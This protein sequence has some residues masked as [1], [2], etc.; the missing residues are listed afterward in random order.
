MHKIK[1][2]RR[3]NLAVTRTAI[4]VTVW[5]RTQRIVFLVS[6]GGDK[7]QMAVRLPQHADRSKFRKKQI[8]RYSN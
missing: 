4:F 1:H 8:L 5:K 2:N 6:P 3:G 7:Q